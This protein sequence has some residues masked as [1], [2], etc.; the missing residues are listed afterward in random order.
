MGVSKLK[1]KWL[2]AR[3]GGVVGCHEGVTRVPKKWQNMARYDKKGI[4]PPPRKTKT[5]S[6]RKPLENRETRIKRGGG[7]DGTRTRD[8]R[9]D[10][11]AL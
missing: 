9:R 3:I 10:R 8:L 5:T 2:L 6:F 1:E 7:I 11:P 4:A